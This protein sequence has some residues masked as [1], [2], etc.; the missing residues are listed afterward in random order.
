MGHPKADEA[1][2]YEN[3]GKILHSARLPN[4]HLKL[5]G[6][7]YSSPNRFE[8]PYADSTRI[9]QAIYNAYGPSRLHWGSDFPVVGQFLTYRHTLDAVRV[10]CPFIPAADL[11]MILGT[12]LAAL[13]AKAPH[14]PP[15]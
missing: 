13:L 3:L 10:H 8:Y 2:P 9:V 1:P 12:G 11:D 7:H 4:I 14:A 5:S 15:A 6:F